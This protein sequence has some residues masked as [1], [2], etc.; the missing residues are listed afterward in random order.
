MSVLSCKCLVSPYQVLD[1][2][3]IVAVGWRYGAHLVSDEALPQVIR[4]AVPDESFEVN[5][6]P[7]ECL[8]LVDLSG[9]F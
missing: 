2:K 6:G 1:G 4:A 7:T 9:Y 8:P 5:Q 3:C